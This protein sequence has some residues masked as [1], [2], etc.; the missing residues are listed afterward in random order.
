MTKVVKWNTVQ[1]L[2]LKMLPLKMLLLRR[3]TLVKAGKWFQLSMFLVDVMVLETVHWW[4]QLPL[5]KLPLK[6]LQLKILLLG[7]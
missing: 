6:M 4:S 5:K 3:T 7:K 2:P 1:R